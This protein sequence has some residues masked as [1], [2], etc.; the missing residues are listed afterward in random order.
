MSYDEIPKTPPRRRPP[1]VTPVPTNIDELIAGFQRA[2]AAEPRTYFRVHDSRLPRTPDRGIF[3]LYPIL[4][5]PIR[6]PDEDDVRV[7][8]Y[9]VTIDN[10][11]LFANDGRASYSIPFHTEMADLCIAAGDVFLNR[12]NQIVEITPSSGH[13]KPD[14]TSIA[15]LNL[16]S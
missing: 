8:R 16:S 10:R 2:L 4:S 6:T 14:W 12:N 3:N 1:P 11:I 7:M 15:V 5:L 9:I 13:F